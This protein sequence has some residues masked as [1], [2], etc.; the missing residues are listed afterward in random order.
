MDGDEI[1][2][3][4][5][6]HNCTLSGNGLSMPNPFTTRRGFWTFAV[7]TWAF[8][9]LVGVVGVGLL[10]H[11]SIGAFIFVAL[12]LTVGVAFW[13]WVARRITR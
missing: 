1:V 5:S 9:M 11:A 12:L 10:V 2:A 4:A 8:A 13:L 3:C 7:L 6:V